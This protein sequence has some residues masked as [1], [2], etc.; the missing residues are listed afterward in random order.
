MQK[1][2]RLPID[3]NT[4]QPLFLI[5]D[6]ETSGLD[7]IAN[8][9]IEVGAVIA[10]F[11]ISKNQLV[12]IDSYQSLVFL[13]GG[14]DQKIT[15]LTGITKT[16]LDFARP[17]HIVQPEWRA[18]LE[19]Y[20]NISHILGHSIEF[21]LGF[22]ASE[23]WYV[24]KD[25]HVIDT[26][27][28]IK[29]V[30]I[31]ISALNLDYLSNL[32][33]LDRHFPILVDNLSHHRALYDSFL[34]AGLFNF[35]VTK[36]S[37]ANCTP[38]FINQFNLFFKLNF[39]NY[40]THTKQIEVQNNT[41][42]FFDS[43][44]QAKKDNLQ[45]YY[46]LFYHNLFDNEQLLVS[47]AKHL[48]SKIIAR[49]VT[50]TLLHNNAF[51][52]LSSFQNKINNYKRVLL[53]IW[54]RILNCNE[55]LFAH[56]NGNKEFLMT[57]LIQSHLKKSTKNAYLLKTWE[58]PEKLIS[59]NYKITTIS[60][61]TAN[62]ND[63]IEIINDLV[64]NMSDELLQLA[65]IRSSIASEAFVISNAYYGSY[66]FDSMETRDLYSNFRI[67]IDDLKS[68]VQN[69]C[70][71]LN[72]QPKTWLIVSIYNLTSNFL[73]ILSSSFSYTINTTLGG[74]Y[75]INFTKSLDFDLAS[76]FVNQYLQTDL[77]ITNLSKHRFE[78]FKSLF[79]SKTA[80]SL[81]MAEAIKLVKIEYKN[82][83]LMVLDDNQDHKFYEE[84]TASIVDILTSFTEQKTLIFT[85]KN[86]VLKSLPN[87][88]DQ[89]GVT[90]LD[91]SKTGSNTKMVT[92][93]QKGYQGLAITSYKN[94]DYF[95][96]ALD[97]N[98]FNV[99]FYPDLYLLVSKSLLQLSGAY[100]SFDFNYLTSK[101]YLEYMIQEILNHYPKA[102]VTHLAD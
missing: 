29:V 85:C 45:D 25:A 51:I 67:T 10:R 37:F 13:E 89:V 58:Y 66:D 98:E 59:E 92:Q 21:D 9:I 72:N 36:I 80:V 2:T 5:I 86:A 82:S 44:G 12:Y 73:E 31:D 18:F 4:N 68:F 11:D 62:L 65:V 78:D 16:E 15:D 35:C 52:L 14:L 23:N 74:S 7:N 90:Y 39:I 94:F 96:K 79:L 88:L 57:S 77:V 30:G 97:L 69:L 102:N 46:S 101:F 43:V 71:T 95:V 28:L 49:S 93:F 8:K 60:A 20:S 24:P 40:Q 19:K 75:N 63:Y 48:E 91:I 6:T 81:E 55:V 33:T 83:D 61:S 17:R 100:N 50:P 87:K 32:H 27:D 22:F 53:Q 64:L 34:C 3:K 41:Y 42:Q 47:T 1:T 76:F 26:L 70:L 38:A 99:I 84:K 56:C 54:Y